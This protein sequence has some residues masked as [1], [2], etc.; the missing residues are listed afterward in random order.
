MQCALREVRDEDL[1]VLFEQWADPVAA[2]M[3]AFTVP[4]HMDRDAFECRWSRLRADETLINRAIVVDGEVAGTIGSW[5][6]PRERE[7]TYWIGRSYWGKGIATCALDAFLTVDLSRPLHARVASDNVASQRVLEK[8]GFRVIA[9]ERGFARAR[10]REIA[11]VVLRLEQAYDRLRLRMLNPL[12]MREA[13]RRLHPLCTASLSF[14]CR[15]LV[16]RGGRVLRREGPAR[17]PR[18]QS[19]FL[20]LLA[21]HFCGGDYAATAVSR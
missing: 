4:D 16:D 7:V 21:V 8:C 15:G 17:G 1:A 6:D 20:R 18:N 12:F 11:E 5:G 9:T 2:Q 3:A 10:S 14:A 19:S 13:K